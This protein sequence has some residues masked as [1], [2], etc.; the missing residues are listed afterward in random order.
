[1]MRESRSYQILVVEDDPAVAVGLV[2]SLG[3]EGFDVH[4]ESTCAGALEWVRRGSSHLVILDVRLPDGSGFDV[5]RK[6]RSSGLRLPILMLTVQGG[7]IDK[8]LG[9]ELGADDYLTKPFL[10]RELVARTH[11]LLRRSYGQLSSAESDVLYVGDL[12]VDLGRACVTRDGHNLTLT[13][14]EYRLLIYLGRHPGRVFSR[15]TLIE[16]VWGSDGQ[17]YDENTV[18]VQVRRLREKIERDP[19]DPRIVVTVPGLGYKVAD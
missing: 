16:E 4:W 14:T 7:E 19:S 2:E 12:V 8:V 17:F 13:A 15:S 1:M 6:V 3:L 5:L 11:A 10:I 18:S 9:L